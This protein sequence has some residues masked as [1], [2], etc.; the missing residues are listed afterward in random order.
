MFQI[1]CA[2]AASCFAVLASIFVASG[3]YG[4]MRENGKPTDGYA[5]IV[6]F[7]ISLVFLAI[8]AGSAWIGGLV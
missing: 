5:A 7:A 2:I 8:S 3:L 4:L 1:I 6:C